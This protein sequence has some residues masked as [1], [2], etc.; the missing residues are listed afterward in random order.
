MSIKTT[1]MDV[2]VSLSGCDPDFDGID[3][4]VTVQTAT[5]HKPSMY[6]RLKAPINTGSWTDPVDTI[7][8]GISLAQSQ[9]LPYVLVE[10]GNYSDAIDVVD[11]IHSLV[12]WIVTS[13]SE[14]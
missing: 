14:I 1:P 13:C 5:T 3:Q 2:S 11:G 6:R 12:D 10:S 9:G 8:E 7:S 4:I